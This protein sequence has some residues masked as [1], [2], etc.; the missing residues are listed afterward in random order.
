MTVHSNPERP[1]WRWTR[2]TGRAV[3]TTRLSSDAMNKANPVMATAQIAL[4]LVVAGVEGTG[5]TRLL[6]AT[7]PE[8]F[9]RE[10]FDGEPFDGDPFGSEPSASDPDPCPWGPPTD[11]WPLIRTQARRT[12]GTARAVRQRLVCD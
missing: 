7:G 12:A 11:R 5:S 9:D 8:P 10:P 4:V 3:E 1:A 2:I 6:G